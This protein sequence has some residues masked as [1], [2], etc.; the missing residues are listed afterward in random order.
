MHSGTRKV[1]FFF[2]S[3]CVSAAPEHTHQNP[4]AVT[5]IHGSLKGGQGDVWESRHFPLVDRNTPCDAPLAKKHFSHLLLARL[6]FVASMVLARSLMF[7]GR[8]LPRS[9]RTLKREVRVDGRFKPPLSLHGPLA[10][11]IH[12]C[13]LRLQRTTDLGMHKGVVQLNRSTAEHKFVLLLRENI[14]CTSVDCPCITVKESTG[15]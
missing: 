6:S 10:H 3:R 1:R 15:L 11:R 8:L 7:L 9:Q 12:G 13:L 14:P 2:L 5:H 4:V